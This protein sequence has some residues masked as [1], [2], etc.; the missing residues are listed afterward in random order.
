MVWRSRHAQQKKRAHSTQHT[1]THTHTHTRTHTHTQSHSHTY[2][3]ARARTGLLVGDRRH[4][5]IEWWCGCVGC[6]IGVCVVAVDS[7]G[8][9]TASTADPSLL[10]W[11]D[12]AEEV[13]KVVLLLVVEN[14]VPRELHNMV[15]RPGTSGKVEVA[16]SLLEVEARMCGA[17]TLDVE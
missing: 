3:R 14:F 11:H 7:W 6:V 4:A 12:V 17:R 10:R 5:G 1:H 8:V 15:A 2:S 9:V 13:P 16:I